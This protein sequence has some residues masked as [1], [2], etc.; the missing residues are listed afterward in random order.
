MPKLPAQPAAPIFNQPSD[1]PSFNTNDVLTRPQPVE[2]P[3]PAMQPNVITSD[4]SPSLATLGESTAPSGAGAVPMTANAPA[5]GVAQPPQDLNTPSSV[6][7]NPSILNAP[8]ATR[9]PVTSP[10]LNNHAVFT[11]FT[12]GFESTA[13]PNTRGKP[14]T[15]ATANGAKKVEV[16]DVIDGHT[17]DTLSNNTETAEVRYASIPFSFYLQIFLASRLRCRSMDWYRW[18]VWETGPCLCGFA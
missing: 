8:P 14:S 2:A 17:I 11:Q 7:S 3:A 15:D 13:R 16:P 6:P 1:Q 9:P 12:S 4:P 18:Q 10:P 5:S